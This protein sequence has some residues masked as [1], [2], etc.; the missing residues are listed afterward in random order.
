VEITMEFQNTFMSPFHPSR[1][2]R[3]CMGRTSTLMACALW[4]GLAAGSVIPAQAKT[5]PK[6]AASAA[7][8]APVQDNRPLPTSADAYRTTK[9][10]ALVPKGWDPSQAFKGLNLLSLKDGDAKANAA[11]A[12]MRQIWDAAPAEKGMEG[13]DIR[14]PGYVVP[15]ESDDKGLREFLLVPYFGACIHTPPPPANQII[16]VT[17]AQ[18]MPGVKAMDALWVLGRLHVATTSSDMGRS[19]YHM[20]AFKAVVYK[21]IDKY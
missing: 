12:R 1:T 4:V 14:I 19:T 17:L 2:K 10:E 11:L 5:A 18:P 7:E 15:L 9:W 21:P 3:K 6:G 16:H 20:D 13:K 8:A